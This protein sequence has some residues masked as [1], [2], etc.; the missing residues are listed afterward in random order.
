MF[1]C[2]IEF[3]PRSSHPHSLHSAEFKT[4]NFY[5]RTMYVLLQCTLAR[6]SR[7]THLGR[8][9]II[10]FY[11]IKQSYKHRPAARGGPSD[12]VLCGGRRRF[13]GKCNYKWKY[14]FNSH[15]TLRADRCTAALWPIFGNWNSVA[16]D[17]ATLSRS[18]SE[19]KWNFDKVR[20]N[21]WIPEIVVLHRFATEHQP[22][23]VKG[24]LEDPVWFSGGMRW[25][26]LL[27]RSKPHLAVEDL[28]FHSLRE[29]QCINPRRMAQ[30]D[31]ERVVFVA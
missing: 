5:L 28:I 22:P 23:S 18:F 8:W 17:T 1:V 14:A 3:P 30:R 13:R 11:L 31:A 12:R 20:D 16:A 15:F 19:E 29:T 9:M 2:V 25:E 26:R 21:D 10:G 6:F 7:H 27:I 4:S 24:R